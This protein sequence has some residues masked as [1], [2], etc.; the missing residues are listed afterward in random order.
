M[1]Y[2]VYAEVDNVTTNSLVSTNLSEGAINYYTFTYNGATQTL[3]LYVNGVFIAASVGTGAII[4][5]TSSLIYIGNDASAAPKPCVNSQVLEIVRHQEVLSATDVQ[6]RYLKSAGLAATTPA[7]DVYPTSYSRTSNGVVLANSKMWIMGRNVPMINESGILLDTT[8]SCFIGNNTV[9]DGST[10]ITT[11][12][13]VTIANEAGSINSS[14]FGQTVTIPLNGLA[15]SAR[16]ADSGYNGNTT[17]NFAVLWRP[18][19]NSAA[20]AYAYIQNAIVS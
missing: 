16:W 15:E 19:G 7:G 18:T 5:D 20:K 1:H 9:T 17:S 10:Q 3:S 4:N 14:A 6:N 2:R 12:A 11:T 13:N 8:R